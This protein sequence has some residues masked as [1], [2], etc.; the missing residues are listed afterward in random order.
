MNAQESTSDYDTYRAI[1]ECLD[2][3]GSFGYFPVIPAGFYLINCVG[4]FVQRLKN[5]QNVQGL[6]ECKLLMLDESRYCNGRQLYY[7]IAAPYH[8]NPPQDPYQGMQ[9]ITTFIDLKNAINKY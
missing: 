5:S 7:K 8:P 9:V 6:F 3:G 1:K 4:E 2:S